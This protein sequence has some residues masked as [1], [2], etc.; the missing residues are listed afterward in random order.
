MD[1]VTFREGMEFIA[2][3]MEKS[4][5]DLAFTTNTLIN[6]LSAECAEREATME[7]V[8]EQV[9]ALLSGPWMPTPVAIESALWPR[10]S[11]LQERTEQIL[12]QRGIHSSTHGKG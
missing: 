7:I 9:L 12:A 10:E 1:D 11:E 6:S 4:A 5:R 8:R 3:L 2:P